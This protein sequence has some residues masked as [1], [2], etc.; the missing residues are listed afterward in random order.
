MVLSK[1]ELKA[2]I[3]SDSLRHNLEKVHKEAKHVVQ[4]MMSDILKS[5]NH[6]LS[7]EKVTLANK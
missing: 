2:L 6:N 4:I 3:K 7:K 1:E 5:H